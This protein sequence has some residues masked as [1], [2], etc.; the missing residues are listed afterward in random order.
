MGDLLMS[1]DLFLR[2]VEA[3]DATVIFLWENNTKHWRIANT[4][5][6]FSMHAIHNLIEQYASIRT[7]GQL[8]LMICLRESNQAIGAIDLYDVNFRHGFATV[9]ILIAEKEQRMLGYAKQALT[10]LIEYAVSI[11]N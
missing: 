7:S 1:Q 6:P 4:E 3:S 5:V 2:A 11:V 8:R 9:G 10:I